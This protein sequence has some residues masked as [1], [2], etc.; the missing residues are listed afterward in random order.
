MAVSLCFLL[1]R[2]YVKM[3][4]FGRLYSDDYV[5]IAAWGMLLATSILWQT[6]VPNQY[7]QYAVASGRTAITPDFVADQT[8][9]MHTLAPLLVLFY[10]CLWA[11]KLS[12]LLFFR[13]LGSNVTGQE[14]WWWSILVVTVLTGAA[15]IGNV[16]WSCFLTSYLYIEGKLTSVVVPFADFLKPTAP[17]ISIWPRYISTTGLSLLMQWRM[18]LRT[19]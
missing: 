8:H 19:A 12:L 15:C 7:E 2:L 3:K 1:F 9:L 14:I 5:I 4:S 16:H 6:V 10:T 17:M 18:W 13:R 11:V